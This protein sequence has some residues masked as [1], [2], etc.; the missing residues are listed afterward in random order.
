MTAIYHLAFAACH[1]DS[2][3]EGGWEGVLSKALKA[4]PGVQ[5]RGLS[6]IILEGS[7]RG[8]VESILG[9]F[10]SWQRSEETG[11]ERGRRRNRVS[12]SP[13]TRACTSAI[14]RDVFD[15]R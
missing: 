3:L 13:R 4:R 8:C 1:S 9:M 5:P 15:A 6:P 7:P 12:P 2:Q 11:R 10:G 14:S